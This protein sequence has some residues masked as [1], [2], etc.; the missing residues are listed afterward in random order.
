MVSAIKA[1]RRNARVPF[2]IGDGDHAIMERCDPNLVTMRL[3]SLSVCS[4]GRL[5]TCEWSVAGESLR[6]VEPNRCL[7][8]NRIHVD[9]LWGDRPSA[10][11][12]HPVTKQVLQL[13]VHLEMAVLLVNAHRRARMLSLTLRRCINPQGRHRRTRLRMGSVGSARSEDR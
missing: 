3:T 9:V 2:D 1:L 5:S 13:V 7:G 4:G 10:I 11:D 12:T 8:Y 6:Y